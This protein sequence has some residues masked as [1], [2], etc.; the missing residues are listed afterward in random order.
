M[1]A[2]EGAPAT[3]LTGTKTVRLEQR[4]TPATKRM[5]EEAA[6]LLGVKPSEFVVAKAAQAAHETISQYGSTVL[7]A[8]D[9]RAFAAAMDATEPTQA[10]RAMMQLHR[11]VTS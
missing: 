10:L 11:E 1:L 3:E 6:A 7:T 4:T 5:I 8:D 9:A 2:F